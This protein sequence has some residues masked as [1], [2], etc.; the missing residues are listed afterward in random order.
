MKPLVLWCRWHEAK[1]RLHGRNADEVWGEL[2]FSNRATPFRYQLHA[3]ILTIDAGAAQK[4]IPLD[5]MGV[6]IADRRAR[7]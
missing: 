1:L 6:E 7:Q 5:E 2:V 3:R 4:S